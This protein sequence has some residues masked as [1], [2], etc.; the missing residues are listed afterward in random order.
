[1]K[2]KKAFLLATF[3]FLIA[4][5]AWY[6]LVGKGLPHSAWSREYRAKDPVR[7]ASTAWEAGDHRFKGIYGDGLTIPGVPSE[8]YYVPRY[9]TTG[10]RGTS[11]CITSS[12][13]GEFQGVAGAY[14]ERY[15]A[16]ILKRLQITP[17]PK[18]ALAE[19][20]IKKQGGETAIVNGEVAAVRLSLR[21]LKDAPTRECLRGLGDIDFLQL[22][23]ASSSQDSDLDPL[24]DLTNPTSLILSDSPITDAGINRLAGLTRLETL[25]LSRTKVSDVGLLKLKSLQRLKVLYLHDTN[26]T[27]AG[28]QHLR[29]L[30]NLESLYLL[31]T[32]VTDDGLVPVGRLVNLT[33][34]V[35]SESITNRGIKHLTEL[36]RLKYLGTQFTKVTPE[37]IAELR[38]SLPHLVLP[39]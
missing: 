16:E 17:S 23:A 31:M 18:A 2:F 4:L 26:V 37:G 7:D 25:M 1:M 34:L 35:L 30:Q 32:K 10:I 8:W 20:L 13:Q 24:I 6:V 27:D 29:E 15:N 36:K 28:M 19:T 14:A 12:E 22:S 38:K 5:A 11:D 21:A 9:G 39:Q 3:C 33:D